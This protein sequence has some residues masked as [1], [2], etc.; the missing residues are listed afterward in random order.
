MF[1]IQSHNRCLLI[2]PLMWLIGLAASS[3]MAQHPNYQVTAGYLDVLAMIALLED[4]SITIDED[5]RAKLLAEGQM[6]KK[7]E[8]SYADGSRPSIQRFAAAEKRNEE[9]AQELQRLNTLRKQLAD[10]P[11]RTQLQVN[12]FNKWKD[13]YNT[14]AEN[15]NKYFEQ[16]V[17]SVNAE[18][19]QLEKNYASFTNRVKDLTNPPAAKIRATSERMVASKNY[20]PG[21]NGAQCNRFVNDYA[22]EL[23]GYRGFE[24]KTADGTIRPLPTSAII[25]KLREEDGWKRIYDDPKWENNKQPYLQ[26]AFQIAAQ[27]ASDRDLVIVG[28][29]TS[30][31]DAHVAIIQSGPMQGGSAAW[32]SVGMGNVK[33]PLIGQAGKSVFT[34]R[35]LNQGIAAEDLKQH[36]LFIY[37][38]KQYSPS[39]SPEPSIND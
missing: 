10:N 5:I 31:P 24:K 28:F 35:G 21:D 23:Y 32:S 34:G 4:K 39:S 18:N 26:A 30:D 13:D 17:A 8:Q 3:A 14:R 19:E 38:Y 9:L 22:K 7:L 27:Y 11:K 37:V 29:G 15:H 6:L 1:R 25:E 2:L 33:F 20:E 36:G 16:L 12:T